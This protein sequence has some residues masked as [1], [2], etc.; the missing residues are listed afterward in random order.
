MGASRQIHPV[1]LA[2]GSGVRLWPLSRP[3]HPKPF[4]RLAGEKTLL[5]ATADRLADPQRF[6]APLVICNKTHRFLVAEQLHRTGGAPQA[7]VLE[8][9]PR[10]TAPAACTAALLLAD[11]DPAALLMLAPSDHFIHDGAGLLSAIDRAAE[12]AAK[13]WIVTFGARPER[14]ETGYGYI[15]QGEALDDCSG[16]FRISRFVEKP[17][18]AT[19]QEYL[20][21]GQFAWNSGMF[22]LSAGCLIE[23]MERH[24]PAIVHACRRALRNA[25]A[26]EDFLR[27]EPTAFKELPNLAFDRAVM[28]RSDRGAVVPIDIGWSDIGSWDALY[29]LAEKDEDGNALSGPV[30]ALD[31]RNTYLHSDAMAIAALGLDGMAVVA[32]ADALL[33]CPRNRSQD[34]ALMVEQL[35]GDP[36]YAPLVCRDPGDADC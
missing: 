14:P 1:I 13:G 25:T 11:A 12:A 36:R 18:L 3:W 27:L 2:G 29:H 7:I 31:S 16:C 10:N 28:E 34:V 32:T 5:Q 21:S 35:A 15:Q 22:L 23:E 20:A 24:E 4:V 19:A 33:V 26:D 9:A 30:V 8:P 6:A 17:D